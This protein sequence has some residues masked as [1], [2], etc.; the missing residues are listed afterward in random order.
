[1]QFYEAR[2]FA[3]RIPFNTTRLERMEYMFHSAAS[4]TGEGIEGFITSS[5]T[6]MHGAFFQA[7]ALKEDLNLSGWDV[8]KVVDLS[9]LFYGSNVVN[10]GISGWDTS[11]AVTMSVSCS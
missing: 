7:R 6:D 11:A 4:F 10:G 9:Q 1:M 2:S 3:G 5:V 8:S